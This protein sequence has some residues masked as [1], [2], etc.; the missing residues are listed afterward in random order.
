MLFIRYFSHSHGFLGLQGLPTLRLGELDE[1]DL[2]F[3]FFLYFGESGS[4]RFSVLRRRLG[5]GESFFLFSG[6]YDGFCIFIMV[7][8]MGRI[9]SISKPV[10]VNK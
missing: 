5:E 6:S 1:S 4:T 9:G 10:C 2:V 3:D 8:V 7:R